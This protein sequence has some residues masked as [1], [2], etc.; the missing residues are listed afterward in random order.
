M[1]IITMSLFIVRHLKAAKV[2]KLVIRQ[3]EGLQGQQNIMI[4]GFKQ[5]SL[6]I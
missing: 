5:P 2:V 4:K 1:D 6:E 3:T